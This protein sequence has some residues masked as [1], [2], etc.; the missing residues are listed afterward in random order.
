MKKNESIEIL[1]ALLE[2]TKKTNEILSQKFTPNI[3]RKTNQSTIKTPVK[4]QTTMAPIFI[5][6]KDGKKV[7]LTSG[8]KFIDGR[9][10]IPKTTDK[11]FLGAAF[12]D[13][14]F[15][16]DENSKEKRSEERM[17]NQFFTQSSDSVSI[18]N[19]TIGVNREQVK[20]R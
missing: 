1:K 4:T 8:G 2:E 12:G 5:G 7:L 9:R 16:D 3:T 15:E 6:R 11:G 14:E 19:S 18:N 20:Q 13:Y 10:I 17:N